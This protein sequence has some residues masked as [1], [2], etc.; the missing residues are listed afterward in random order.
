M[1]TNKNRKGFI[2]LIFLMFFV[3]VAFFMFMCLRT[4]DVAE[5]QMRREQGLPEK[6]MI[7][8]KLSPVKEDRTKELE[9]RIEELE[10]KLQEQKPN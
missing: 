10:K 2:E 3:I 8:D 6:E 1:K 5:N 7:T 4:M 9:K